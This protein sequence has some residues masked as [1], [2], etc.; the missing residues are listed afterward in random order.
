M[1]LKTTKTKTWPAKSNEK[2]VISFPPRQVRAELLSYHYASIKIVK[3]MQT[4]HPHIYLHAALLAADK[5]RERKSLEGEDASK[6]F[7]LHLGHEPRTL[8]LQSKHAL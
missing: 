5:T 2:Q 7:V 3:H 8:A 6:Q 1:F 4:T